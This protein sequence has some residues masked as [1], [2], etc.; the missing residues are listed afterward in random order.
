MALPAS[1]L[2]R[3]C[4][5]IADFVSAGIDASANSVRVLLGSPSEAAKTSES[6][7]RV[8]LFFYRIEPAG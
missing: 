8:N 7:H 5:A 6:Q 1:S 3:V 2:S 4:R